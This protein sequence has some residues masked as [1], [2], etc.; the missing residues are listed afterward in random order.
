GHVAR[1]LEHHVFEQMRKTGAPRAFVP[2]ADFVP[3]IDRHYRRALLRRKD[4]AQAVVEPVL[5]EWNLYHV[6][7]STLITL[8]SARSF[9]SGA[10]DSASATTTAIARSGC[11]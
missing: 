1:T 8:P 4:D 9:R 10:T 2:R 5:L 11:R 3:E 6:G 7:T